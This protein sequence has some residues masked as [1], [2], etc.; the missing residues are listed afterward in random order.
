V[1]L[2]AV[3]ALA[4]VLTGSAAAG[5]PRGLSQEGR[6]LWNFEA[7]LH[8]T[9]GNRPVCSRGGLNFVSPASKCLPL[10]NW[11]SYDYVFTKA[12]HTAFHLTR[13]RPSICNICA[14]VRVASRYV[15]C[16]RAERAFLFL[17]VNRATSSINCVTS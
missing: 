14:P 2:V 1:R 7:L 3:A 11:D 8:D 17:L 4:L 15:A 16:D 5:P 12:R 6:A 10:A 13:H 9:F